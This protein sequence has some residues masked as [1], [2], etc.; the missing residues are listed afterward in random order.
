MVTVEMFWMPLPLLALRRK[1]K[2][3]ND[4]YIYIYICLITW[5]RPY[6]SF[7]YT[8]YRSYSPSPLSQGDELVNLPS[9]DPS[10]GQDQLQSEYSIN[11]HA[12]R[13]FDGIAFSYDLLSQSL[14]FFQTGVW[15]RFLVSRLPVGPDDRVL[16]ICTGTG[17][18][19]MDIARN[20]GA[21]VVGVDI[22]ENMRL[23]ARSNIS[24]AG[25]A[26][27]VSVLGGRAESLSFK[28]GSVDGIC[29][30][31]LLRY[32]EDPRHT[33]GEIVRVL[34]PGGTLASL[35]FGIPKNIILYNLW[36]VY[37]RLAIP[38]ATKL[39]SPGWRYVG[40]FLGP[41]ISGFYQKHSIEDVR[42]M[43]LEAGISNV[44]VKQ[45]TWGAGVVMWGIKA[46]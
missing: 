38:L 6:E 20:T 7:C 21:E 46:P 27:K 11:L 25:L 12:S 29:F 19:A 17:G 24:K 3:R 41:S 13:L 39:L 18:V 44:Q 35:E 5:G 34:M 15:R 14:S 33:L 30:T 2:G 36:K 43:W 8:A 16:D 32:V 31:Y 23:T 40:G 10:P 42:Q 4:I 1:G 28:D 26:A 22:S 9:A 45:L 37:T